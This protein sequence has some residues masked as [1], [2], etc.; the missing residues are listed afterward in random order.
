MM[1][2]EESKKPKL[3]VIDRRKLQPESKS[4]DS[5]KKE[6]LQDLA[7]KAVMGKGKVEELSKPPKKKTLR[8]Q[9][10]E[11]R[12][13]KQA[14]KQERSNK[15]GCPNCKYMGI[16]DKFLFNPQL[17]AM[18]CPACGVFFMESRLRQKVMEDIKRKQ[19]SG[20]IVPK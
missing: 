18:I 9:V 4:K 12:L 16:R 7:M 10:D 20:I 5:N 1:G 8:E 2:K 11:R 14:T 3:T 15:I 19:E 17:H 13:K 6:L